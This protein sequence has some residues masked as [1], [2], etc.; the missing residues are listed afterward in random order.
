MFTHVNRYVAITQIVIEF[1]SEMKVNLGLSES[2]T[3]Q[4]KIKYSV[5]VIDIV[6]GKDQAC[7]NPQK[8]KQKK[9]QQ[10]KCNWIKLKRLIFR[11]IAQ[12]PMFVFLVLELYRVTQILSI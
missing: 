1:Q 12:T 4:K 10:E 9:T 2:I 7:V 6:V 5:T 11:K 8:P 3:K